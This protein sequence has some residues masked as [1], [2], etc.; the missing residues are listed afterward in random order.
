MELRDAVRLVRVNRLDDNAVQAD[1]TQG[2]N[3][4]SHDEIVDALRE[5]Q[6]EAAIRADL[7][8]DEFTASICQIPVVANQELYPLHYSVYRVDQDC[9]TYSDTG[10]AMRLTDEQALREGRVDHAGYYDAY[11]WRPACF[12]GQW[13]KQTAARARH[14]FI[15]ADA[16]GKLYLRPFP[17]CN[18]ATYVDRDGNTQPLVMRLAVY[19]RPIWPLRAPTDRFEIDEKYHR[20]L[21]DFALGRL[22]EKNDSDASNQQLSDKYY[23]K[24]D[25]SFGDRDS[26]RTDIS[27]RDRERETVRPWG[28]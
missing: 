16:R 10:R 28:I 7:L 23:T 12:G 18:E 9:V 11:G 1:G 21:I 14:Y 15:K 5:A 6:D 22:Y 17:I 26:A 20:R 24:F 8:R 2:T 3:Q 13:E 25:K 4:W 27:R 19:R